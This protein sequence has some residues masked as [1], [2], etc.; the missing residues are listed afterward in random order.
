M[1]IIEADS[2]DS[3][4]LV[5]DLV[6]ISGQYGFQ[7]YTAAIK[8]FGGHSVWC[9]ESNDKP[10][11]YLQSANAPSRCINTIPTGFRTLHTPSELDT[12]G[13]PPDAFDAEYFSFIND[14]DSPRFKLCIYTRYNCDPGPHKGWK[15]KI[16]AVTSLIS[17]Y[18]KCDRIHGYDL[19]YL[20]T[21]FRIIDANDDCIV[22][23]DAQKTEESGSMRT[24][25]NDVDS[26]NA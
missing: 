12:W 26:G 11:A 6:P 2:F 8:E 9:S 25:K 24:V 5:P 23:V 22:S 13:I 17:D 21:S 20:P 18:T 4:K 14:P 1:D 15:S 3:F 19:G 16:P 7:L 10:G